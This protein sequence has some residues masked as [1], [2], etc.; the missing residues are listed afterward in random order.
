MDND[1]DN[2]VH[3]DYDCVEPT[4]DTEL[5]CEERQSR[6]S[7]DNHYKS[8]FATPV[9]CGPNEAIKKMRWWNGT[10]TQ[11]FDYTCCKP[12]SSHTYQEIQNRAIGD[13]NQVPGFEPGTQL[14]LEEA[15][16]ECSKYADCRAFTRR[17]SDGATWLKT[18]TNT[19]SNNRDNWNSYIKQS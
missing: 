9:Q 7:L 4:N 12:R 14:T 3:F 17:K 15:K 16:N 5:E 1:W 6:G 2:S 8:M 18:V 19:G 11:G 13:G 10:S